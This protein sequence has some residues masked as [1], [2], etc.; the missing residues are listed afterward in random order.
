MSKERKEDQSTQGLDP[1]GETLQ[2]S[3]LESSGLSSQA[4]QKGH[5]SIKLRLGDSD[6][7]E[8]V[9]PPVEHI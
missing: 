1:A 2:S 8:K 3:A 5:T 7:A 6:K 9:L 4:R